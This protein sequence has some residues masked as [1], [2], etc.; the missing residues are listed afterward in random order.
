MMEGGSAGSARRAIDAR[1]RIF[2][3]D[4]FRCVYCGLVFE[5]VELT[6]DHVE[7]RM[8]GGDRS[9]GNLVTCCVACNREKEGEPAWSF[10]ARRPELRENFLR[11]AT[12]VWPRLRRAI[13][14]A[15]R[16]NNRKVRPKL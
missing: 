1:R 6:L 7:P 9:G 3:R 10:L 4:A 11:H 14:Q 8:R 15:A 5:E 2:E 16:I 13:E 12:H